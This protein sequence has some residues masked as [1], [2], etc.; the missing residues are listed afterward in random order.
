MKKKIIT[1][2][3]LII[4]LISAYN[5]NKTY[6]A[7]NTLYYDGNTKDFT[8]Y[9]LN[10][11]DLF[12]NFKDLIPGDI[13]EE[14]INIKGININKKTNL[15]IRLDTN[16][17][18]DILEYLKITLYKDNEELEDYQGLIKIT[19]L[20]N[21][22]NIELKL[23]IEVPTSVGNVIEDQE[24]YLRWTFLVE[25]NDEN[26]PVAVPVTSSDNNLI[27]YLVL[28]ITSLIMMVFILTHKEESN[29]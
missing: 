24:R 23:K 28:C 7:N 12:S 11:G 22:S 15:Y 4:L 29:E 17:D 18:N 16:I 1:F 25:E 26:E 13:R 10:Q 27:I 19:D 21:D 6:N 3:L 20:N 14:T 5:I 8:Y 2:I 9:N